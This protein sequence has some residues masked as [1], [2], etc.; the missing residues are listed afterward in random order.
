[1]TGLRERVCTAGIQSGLCREDGRT[2]GFW[3]HAKAKLRA[4]CEAGHRDNRMARNHS[5]P[6]ALRDSRQQQIRFHRGK[7]RAN[8]LTRSAAKGE[9]S[10]AGKLTGPLF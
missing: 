3:R 4:Q 10:E 8:A 5:E 6:E 2:H 1:M 7:S 9:V